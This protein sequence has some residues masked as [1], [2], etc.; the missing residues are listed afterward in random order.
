MTG[1][2]QLTAALA[3]RYRI[4]REL[5]AGG[6]ATVYLAEDLRHHRKVAVKV[7]RPELAAV[8]GAE[9]FLA[10][11]KTTANLQHPHILPLFDSGAAGQR[12]GEGSTFLFYVMPYVEGESLRDRLNREKQLPITDAVRI[13]TEIASALDYAHRHG[14][15]HRDIKPE[16]IMLHDGSALVADC[17]IALA[18]SKAGTR[19]TETGMS[20]GTPHYMSPEQAMGEREITAR[21]DVY[22][23]G[24]VTYEMLAGDPPFTGST[25]QAIVAKVMTDEPA[26]LR[27]H[28][29]A[30]PEQVED[31]VLTALE[32]LP[33]DR[34]GSAAEFADALSGRT[35]SRRSVTS[36]RKA[37]TGFPPYRLTALLVALLITSSLAA[38]GWLRPRPTAQFPSKLA[39][40]SPGLGG[41]GAQAL[42]RQLT[43]TP[44]GSAVVYVVVASDGVNRLMHQPLDASAPTVITGSDGLAAP[45]VS[46]DGKWVLGVWVGRGPFR[47]PLEGGSPTVLP[48]DVATGYADW[49]KN[50][51]LWLGAGSYAEGGVMQLMGNDSLV[52]RLGPES[53]DLEL[54]QILPSGKA[55]MLKK[56]GGSVTGQIVIVDLKSGKVKVLLDRPTVDVRYTSGYL[57]SIGPDG[58]LLAS[59]YDEKGEKITDAPVTIGTGISIT[60]NGFAQF[61]VAR[62]GTV[63]YIPEEPRSLVFF[64]RSGAARHPIEAG[65]SYHAPMF[66]PDGRRLS[67]DFI[68]ADGRDV[69][70]LSLDQGI[71]T[72]A[73]FDKN[74]HDATWTPDGR[75]ITYSSIRGTGLAV[76]RVRPG[77]AMPAESLFASSSL[78][79]TGLWLPDSSRLLTVTLGLS[80]GT[81][82]DLAMLE[83]GGHGPLTALVASK[84]NEAYPSISPD[85]KWVAFVSDQSGQQEVYVRPLEGDGD[86]VQVSLAGGGEPVW[87]KN[88]QELFYRTGG[89]TE[90]HLVAARFRTAPQFEI[91]SRQQLFSM[92]DIVGTNPHTNYDVS[93]D[94]R[95][96]AMVQASPATR[97]MIIQNLPGL[98]RRLR[99][100]TSTSP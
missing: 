34:F 83:H 46:P 67:T 65:H 15:I 11:I 22:A 61:A 41:S 24:A 1:P 95:S 20:L 63:A 70:I 45:I 99:G 64:D 33:A 88:S 93:P 44:D 50:G 39:I 85:G 79:Y 77:S 94:G 87:A 27:R 90:P 92:A 23:L 55:L 12:G 56:A 5:G 76:F 68:S 28:R 51:M 73:T 58:I 78:G 62:N 26:P 25:A 31:A 42:Q 91:L 29:K 19:M 8:I 47:L 18:A 49:D 86:Q 6:M 59:G 89:T 75:F 35:T 7:L 81:G 74:G 53:E 52:H 3:D 60:G 4:E 9:R 71:L 82:Q 30:I 10:E 21:S 13:A 98:V 54:E 17:G 100:S 38:W 80:A 40:L 96:F 16:N 2:A 57:V 48:G 14:V 69:W 97:I 84:F 32:K 36:S 43:L 37:P 72:R 66:S